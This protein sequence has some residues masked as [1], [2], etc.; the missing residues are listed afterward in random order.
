MIDSKT[1]FR[2]TW[3]MLLSQKRRFFFLLSIITLSVALATLAINM[4][5]V[6][7]K[8]GSLLQ[9]DFFLSPN[10]LQIHRGTFSNENI[11]DSDGIVISPDEIEEIKE[12][13]HVEFV[14][15]VIQLRVSESPGDGINNS[16]FSLLVV[17][18]E[19]IDAY[20]GESPLTDFK[21]NAVPLYLS[22]SM[23]KEVPFL[24]EKVPFDQD[25]LEE[26]VI[27]ETGMI[28]LSRYSINTPSDIAEDSEVEINFQVSAVHNKPFS[29]IA[30]EKVEPY[31]DLVKP[32]YPTVSVFLESSEYQS[33]IV[34]NLQEKGYEVQTQESMKESFQRGG[35]TLKG[36]TNGL[37]IFFSLLA[38]LLI[39]QTIR[40]NV[41]DLQ[42]EISILRAMGFTKKEVVYFI[43]IESFILT[44]LSSVLGIALALLATFIFIQ[45]FVLG[46]S[47][48]LLV[49]YNVSEIL[50]FSFIQSLVTTVTILILS[51]V[52]NFIVAWRTTTRDIANGL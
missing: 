36:I 38:V 9:A 3:K 14:S 8:M 20:L 7:M 44:L 18:Q 19:I 15:P 37:A 5:G 42:K 39:F 47:N 32:P 23:A 51:L 22:R 35:D 26:D 48:A 41:L 34:S 25:Y 45:F 29:Y 11:S 13:E 40:K 27:G 49:G 28:S 21:A 2:I 1:I 12:I 16:T 50:S 6:L 17:R 30:F 4:G 33:Q 10:E 46:K 43:E 52:I 31:F 24:V